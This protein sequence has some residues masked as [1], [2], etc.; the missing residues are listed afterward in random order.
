MLLL[1]QTFLLQVAGGELLHDTGSDDM[2]SVILSGAEGNLMS[3]PFWTRS[4]EDG[5]DVVVM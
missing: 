2:S 4:E 5:H 3:V 1:H